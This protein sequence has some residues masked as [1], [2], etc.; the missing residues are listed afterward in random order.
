MSRFLWEDGIISLCEASLFFVIGLFFMEVQHK[1]HQ[2]LEKEVEH[3][4]QATLP[5]LPPGKKK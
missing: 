3:G 2:R 5:V 4:G 1:S